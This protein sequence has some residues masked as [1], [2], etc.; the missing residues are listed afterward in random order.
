MTRV[1]SAAL[2]LLGRLM[3]AAIFLLSGFGKLSAPADTI[4]YIR[5]AGLP[6]ATVAYAVALAVELGGGLAIVAGLFTPLVAIA[7]AVFSVATAFAFHYP[8]TDMG[9][10]VNFWKNVA[11]AGGLLVLASSGAGLWSLDGLR[12]R[13]LPD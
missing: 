12:A 1:P 2:L 4:G 5:S 11:M 7:L 13:R 9:Q 8:M 3:L 10:F 6:V